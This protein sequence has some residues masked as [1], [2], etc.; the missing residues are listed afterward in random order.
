[1]RNIFWQGLG[2]KLSLDSKKLM[3]KS[4]MGQICAESKILM[5]KREIGQ[6]CAKCILDL[7]LTLN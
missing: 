6:I 5:K 4:K 1:M 2:P 7:S 3:K